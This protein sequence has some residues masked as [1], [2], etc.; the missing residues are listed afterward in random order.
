MVFRN[1]L[2]VLPAAGDFVLDLDESILCYA[3]GVIFTEVL[4]AFLLRFHAPV[5][6]IKE[7][8]TPRS[9]NKQ[10]EKEKKIELCTTHTG[11]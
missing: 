10:A 6:I 11:F 7:N 3:Y 8:E 1:P 5:Y 2:T 4:H 9:K